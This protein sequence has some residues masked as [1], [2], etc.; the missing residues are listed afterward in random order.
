MSYLSLSSLFPHHD[1]SELYV[2]NAAPKIGEKIT[3]HV[4]VPNTYSFAKAFIRIYE[5][6]EPR[7]YE[8]K[9]DKKGTVES[10]WKVKVEIVNLKTS[11]RFVFIS[12]SKYEWLNARGLNDH[13]VHSND[14]FKIVAI[15]EYPR[16]I[17]SAV[18]YQIFPDRFAKS[19]IKKEIP[20]WAVLRRWELP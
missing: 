6:G 10:W 14:D 8:L 15:P 9:L 5:D 17:R 2:S 18:F 20:E 7:S 1:G 12:E 16:W 4:R 19:D 11:Y 3:L 13:D